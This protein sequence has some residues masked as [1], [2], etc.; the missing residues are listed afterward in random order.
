MF[1][2]TAELPQPRSR[3]PL[4]KVH[5]APTGKPPT[6]HGTPCTYFSCFQWVLYGFSS[7]D[8]IIVFHKNV[9]VF[10]RYDAFPMKRVTSLP[11]CR[12]KSAASLSQASKKHSSVSIIGLTFDMQA[13]KAILVKLSV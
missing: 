2:L 12:L 8:L 10:S 5:P 13:E 6:E 3:T 11:D 1:S 7:F 9:I 4:F